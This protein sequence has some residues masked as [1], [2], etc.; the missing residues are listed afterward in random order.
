M[1]SALALAT[2]GN[3]KHVR[4]AIQMPAGTKE[5]LIEVAHTAGVAGSSVEL[6]LLAVQAGRVLL[7][8]K[9]VIPEQ[10]TLR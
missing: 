4:I 8:E 1:P 2:T 3:R 6:R 10:N 5:R 9:P 7:D